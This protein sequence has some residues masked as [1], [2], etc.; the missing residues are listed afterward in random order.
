MA[1][2]E[3]TSYN[4]NNTF[5]LLPT[6]PGTPLRIQFFPQIDGTA[7]SDNI[8]AYSGDDIAN[9]GGGDDYIDGGQGNDTLSGD[10]DNDF[11][12][13]YFGNDQL[14]G[15]TG[16][17]TLKGGRDNDILRGGSGNDVLIGAGSESY[18]TGFE[19]PPPGRGEIDTLTGGTRRDTFV[20]GDA[21]N[22]YYDDGNNPWF[23][24]DPERGNSDFALIT[25]FTNGLDTIQ[26]KG[27]ETYILEPITVGSISG[28]GI[29]VN[30]G[31]LPG[32]LFS[33][34]SFSFPINPR[35]PI[36]DE[37]IGIVQGVSISALEIN[38]GSSITTIT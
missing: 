26:L 6:P 23:L 8:Y 3:G 30:K 37:L 11:I 15:G 10:A 38:S 9:G 13:G 22:I 21:D 17:D 18:N 32:D 34:G 24:L 12:E 19:D 27:G 25:D 36:A 29:F 5:Q 2:I 4:D 14:N 16:N 35:R 31:V 7:L 20:L 1:I 33:S 28:I